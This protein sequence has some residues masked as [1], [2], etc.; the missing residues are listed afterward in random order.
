[1]EQFSSFFV[2][3]VE[4]RIKLDCANK[5]DGR[6]VIWDWK[7]GKKETDTG[8]SLQM[9]CYAAY[10][11]EKYRADLTDIITRRFNLHR[12]VVHEHIATASSLE[13]IMDYIRG[14]IAD[15][16]ALLEDEAENKADEERFA[17]VARRNVCGR[18]NF[19]KVCKPDL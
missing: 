7:T 13:E 10:A 8:L 1:V 12:G 2:D 4:L 9:G 3:G 5:E 11:K 14:S 6:I 19:F 17:K 15:M 16:T 18:C